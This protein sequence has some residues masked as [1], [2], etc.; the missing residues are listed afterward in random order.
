MAG[1][2]KIKHFIAG[3]VSGHDGHLRVTKGEN[4]IVGGG[5]KERHEQAVDL[6]QEVDKEFRRDPPQ[7]PGEARMVVRDAAKK[8]G[9]EPAPKDPKKK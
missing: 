7:T 4:F 5:K 9:L 3:V 8:V 6:V 1:K 2:K